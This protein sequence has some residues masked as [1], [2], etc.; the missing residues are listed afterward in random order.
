M[1]RELYGLPSF[2]FMASIKLMKSS[3][4]TH[5]A[6]IFYHLFFMLGLED[7]MEH[8]TGNK[9]DEDPECLLEQVMYHALRAG[10]EIVR[11]EEGRAKVIYIWVSCFLIM[12]LSSRKE[13]GDSGGNA[14]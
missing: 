6:Y 10:R 14:G 3:T 1:E 13:L 8:N 7:D 9:F 11:K 5:S 4:A 2:N 12:S